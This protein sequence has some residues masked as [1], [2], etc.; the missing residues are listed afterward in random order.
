MGEIID[1]VVHPRIGQ[2]VAVQKFGGVVEAVAEVKVSGVG[3]V[4]LIAVR[5][6]AGAR[7]LVGVRLEGVGLRSVK[8][9]AGLIHQ[10]HNKALGGHIQPVDGLLGGIGR[11]GGLCVQI[12]ADQLVAAGVR[13]TVGR[14]VAGQYGRVNIFGQYAFL[15]SDH[16]DHVKVTGV[17]RS[18]P[19]QEQHTIGIRRYD[20]VRRDLVNGLGLAGKV[21]MTVAVHI[22]SDGTTPAHGASLRRCEAEAQKAQ[23]KCKE[24]HAGFLH[25]NTLLLLVVH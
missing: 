12:Q 2:H 4:Y 17:V 11:G 8:Q 14:V 5:H 9:V 13:D 7:Q 25:N 18:V 19:A 21:D 20:A 6:D 15:E 23:D 1:D 3:E 16:V 24:Q 10:L 22:G